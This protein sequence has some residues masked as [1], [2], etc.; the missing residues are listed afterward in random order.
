MSWELSA[1]GLAVGLLAGAT[2]MGGGSLMTPVLVLVFGFSPSLAVGTDLLHGACFK[3]V[4]AFRH[5]RLGNVQARLSGWMFIGSGP[6]SLAGVATAAWLRSRYGEGVQSTQ[7]VILGVA[8]ILGGLGL[9]AKSAVRSRSEPPEHFAMTHRDRIAA[10]LIGVGGGYV[11]GLTSVGSGVFFGLTMLVAFPLRSAK[12]VGTDIFHAAALLWVAGLGHFVAGNVDLH[13]VTWLLTGSIPGVLL[14]SGLTLRLSDRLLRSV[15][16]VTLIASGVKLVDFAH[17]S[18]VAIGVL[19]L[20]VIVLATLEL[21]RIVARVP[22]PAHSAVP[23][24]IPSTASAT[25]LRQTTRSGSHGSSR[26]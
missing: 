24:A 15:L 4:G 16:A 23:H 1:A 26:L 5:R 13:A 21:R 11:V 25:S 12:V 19:S 9:F 17:S 10:V 18:Q 7:G 14:S 22:T 20:G 6:A 8:L 2:G 3:T